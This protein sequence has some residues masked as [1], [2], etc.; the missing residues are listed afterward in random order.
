MDQN[1]QKV[2]DNTL[3]KWENYVHDEGIKETHST[4]SS[5]R[6]GISVVQRVRMF[7]DDDAAEK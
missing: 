5:D 7:L 2:L 6:S 3:L 1:T 4:G